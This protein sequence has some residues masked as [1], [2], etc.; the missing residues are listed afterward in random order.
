MIEREKEELLEKTMFVFWERL[1][2]KPSTLDVVRKNNQ[3]TLFVQIFLALYFLV[4]GDDNQ[5]KHWIHTENI[6]TGGIPAEQMLTTNGME[7]VAR[8]LNVICSK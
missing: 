1:E 6:H 5:M 2:M 8:Y 7:A 3:S 4:G